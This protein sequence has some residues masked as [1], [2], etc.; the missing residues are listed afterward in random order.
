MRHSI[1]PLLSLLLMMAYADS[2]A[3]T[4]LIVG[5]KASV[6]GSVICSYN[7][8]GFAFAGHMEHYVPGRHAAGDSLAIPTWLRIPTKH[9]ISQVDY[10]YNMIAMLNEKQV[11]ITETT[12]DGRLELVNPEGLLDYYTLMQ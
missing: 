1:F 5:K 12:F 2:H 3:C 11:S 10:T 9:Y 8:D 6:D 4:N 7:N